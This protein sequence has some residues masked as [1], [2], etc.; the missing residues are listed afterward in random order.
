MLAMTS[1]VP[2][3]CRS[4]EEV[5]DL[6]VNVEGFIAWRGGELIQ[7]ALPEL[8][9]DQRELLISG[10]CPKCWEQMFPSDEEE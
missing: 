4:C 10:I 7:N 5:T 8:D 6:S 2:V 3:P 9:A 1:V